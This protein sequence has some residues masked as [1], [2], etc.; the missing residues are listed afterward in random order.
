MEDEWKG[1][2]QLPHHF[3]KGNCSLS[4]LLADWDGD[5]VLG[6]LLPP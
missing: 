4:T 6:D 1:Y 3:L 2:M 5:R